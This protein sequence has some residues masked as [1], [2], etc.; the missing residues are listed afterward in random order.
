MWQG[1]LSE[2]T[3][4]KLT[5]QFLLLPG[6]LF[7][8]YSLDLPEQPA[9]VVLQTG[10]EL[11]VSLGSHMKAFLETAVE[12]GQAF[13]AAEGRHLLGG[14]PLLQQN[15]GLGHPDL[16]AQL[17]ETGTGLLLQ[18]PGKVLR[19][20]PKLLAYQLQS[21]AFVVMIR[22]VADDLQ[23]PGVMDPK[24]VYHDLD[25]ALQGL[26]ILHRLTYE[27]KVTRPKKEA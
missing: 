23:D 22:D 11:L 5:L 4:E 14:R 27:R 24:G 2:P 16:L 18:K 21:H 3:Y 9:L 17:P 26:L 1:I 7:G 20:V 10:P 19:G 13:P 8:L 6:S 15:P 25:P 12:R